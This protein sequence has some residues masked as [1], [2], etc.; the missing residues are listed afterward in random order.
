MENLITYGIITLVSIVFI[1]VVAVLIAKLYTRAT[2]QMAFV[3]TGLGGTK[4]VSDG[5]AIVLPMFHETVQVNMNTIKLDVDKKNADA[6]ITLDRMRVDIKAEFYVRVKQQAESIAMAAQTLGSKTLNANELKA[7]MEGKFVDALRAVAA[8]M[9][10]KE[11][12]EKRTDF[13]SKVQ[14][15]VTEDLEKNGLE[16]ESVSLTSFDQTNKEYFN[17]ENAFDAEGLTA[18]T[19]EIENRKKLR[20]DI[21]KD[22]QLQIAQ[23]DLSF[24]EEQAKIIKNQEFIK[25]NTEKEISFQKAEQEK[26]IANNNAEKEKERALVQEKLE[27]EKEQAKIDREKA[28]QLANIEK[29]KNVTQENINK[30]KA[31]QQAKIVQQREIELAEQE[32][33]IILAQKSEEEAAANAKAEQARA[34]EVEA[35]QAVITVEAVATAKRKQQVEVLEAK[36]LAEKESVA[37]IVQAQAEEQA[38]QARANAVIKEAEAEKDANL[39]KAQAEEKLNEVRATGARAINEAANILTQEQVNLQIKLRLLEQLPKIIAE[40]VRPMEKIDSIK[41]VDMGNSFGKLNSGENVSVEGNSNSLPDQVVQAALK[42]KA[43]SPLIDN[44]LSDVG[45]DLKD[46]NKSI[47]KS[48]TSLNNNNE[49][50]H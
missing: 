40:S 47:Q 44:L 37:V 1:V 50:H 34:N 12:H 2:K 25:L 28:I 4:V 6:L 18:L 3:R 10:M 31:I 11:L 46:L 22:T 29:D 17:P 33:N 26:E 39:L 41:I 35:K 30:D 16:L 21:E 48:T 38:S 32:K 5:G 23:K 43:V 27:R 45:I 49:E 15:S 19:Q 24:N 7:L 20:N 13:V 14:S 42:H 9:T 8:S 36:T